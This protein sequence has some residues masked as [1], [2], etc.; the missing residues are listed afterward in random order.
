MREV[1]ALAERTG[2]IVDHG[3]SRGLMANLRAQQDGGWVTAT[4]AEVRNRA[5]LVLFV[6]T[7]AQAMA[8]RLVERC[9]A[10][11]DTLFGP[12]RRR[13]VYLG[14]GLQAADRIGADIVTLPCPTARLPETVALLRALVA[15]ARL[16][17]AAMAD[18]ATA[19]LQALADQLRSASYAVIV[20]SAAEVPGKHPDLLTSTLAGLTRELNLRTRCAGLPLAGPDNVIGVNQVCAWQTGGPLRTSFASGGPGPR[21]GALEHRRPCSTAVAWT[22]CCGSAACTSSLCRR[23]RPRR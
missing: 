18:A 13:L 3:G 22:A 9:L 17:A 16:A 7:D 19:E 2:G 14:S 12:L 1:L 6:G 5:D 15:G 21:P 10:P 20:W 11:R 8:P 4:L 23:R